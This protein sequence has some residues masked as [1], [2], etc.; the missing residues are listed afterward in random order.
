[1]NPAI[2]ERVKVL[3]ATRNG[4]QLTAEEKMLAKAKEMTNQRGIK[5]LNL[6]LIG[7]GELSQKENLKTVKLLISKGLFIDRDT[8]WELAKR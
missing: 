1:M 2:L 8:G 7:D 4:E 5:I 3:K 6:I